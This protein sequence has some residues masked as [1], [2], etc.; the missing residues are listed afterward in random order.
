MVLAGQV[1]V[2]LANLLRLGVA[3]DAQR[4][5]IVFLCS[6]GHW[7]PT[8]GDL[9]KVKRSRKDAKK[10]NYKLPVGL[11]SLAPPREVPSVLVHLRNRAQVVRT[12]VSQPSLEFA[13]NLPKER[14]LEQELVNLRFH[15]LRTAALGTL[16]SNLSALLHNLSPL[17]LLTPPRGAPLRRS[18]PA[19]GREGPP[20]RWHA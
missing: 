13:L 6:N 12:V 8:F 15:E 2:S 17:S 10:R 16:H 7:L 3:V 14:R 1:P 4:R 11:R 20:L 9:E 18:R 5:V 19:A